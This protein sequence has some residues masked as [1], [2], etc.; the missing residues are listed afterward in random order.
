MTSPLLRARV[1]PAPV[2]CS[3]RAHG[4]V[5]DHVGDDPVVVAANRARVASLAGLPDPRSWVW[6]RQ[7]HGTAVFVARSAPDPD[8][9]DPPP[10]RGRGRD[11]ARGLPLAIVTAD[12]APIVLAV[13]DA[14]AVVHAGHRGL[15][16]GIVAAGVEAVRTIGS[17][18]VHA[19]LGPCIRPAHYEFGA[20]D[21]G[22][23]RA[24]LRSECRGG[25]Q[26]GPAR[27]RHA[28]G[29]ARRARAGGRG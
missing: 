25:D 16:D 27:A 13:D 5:G 7:V 1:G 3:S 18:E 8:R 10:D 12:C 9:A 20:D 19:F 6:V 2:W 26:H 29:R 22:A 21:L 23:P 17:G 15:L 11:R 14:V 4:N 24:T 28:R